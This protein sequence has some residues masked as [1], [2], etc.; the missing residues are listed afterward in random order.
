MSEEG[1]LQTGYARVPMRKHPGYVFTWLR[2]GAEIYGFVEREDNGR[3]VRGTSGWYRTDKP[4]LA[5]QLAGDAIQRA[6]DAAKV[7]AG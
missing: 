6:Q 5:E 3:M 2:D 1:T 7:L 4:D